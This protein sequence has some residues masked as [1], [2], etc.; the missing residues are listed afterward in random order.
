MIYSKDVQKIELA[1]ELAGEKVLVGLSLS[2][3]Y[4]SAYTEVEKILNEISII[5][6]Q[7]TFLFIPLTLVDN[8][9]NH[10]RNQSLKMKL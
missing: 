6:A 7:I 3:K 2:K 9:K 1:L 10:F 4:N 5:Y 8:R